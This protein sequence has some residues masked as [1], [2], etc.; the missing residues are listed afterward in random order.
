MMGCRQAVLDAHAE[1]ARR[2]RAMVS[3]PSS[4]VWQPPLVRTRVN[5]SAYSTGIAATGSRAQSIAVYALLTSA[6]LAEVGSDIH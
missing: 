5:P 3:A 2:I 4:A 1:A 6:L